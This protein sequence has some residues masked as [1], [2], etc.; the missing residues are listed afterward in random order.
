MAEKLELIQKH[1]KSCKNMI[2]MVK[3]FSKPIGFGGK[4]IKKHEGPSLQELVKNWKKS[5]EL[6]SSELKE[7]T[8]VKQQISYRSCCENRVPIIID[9]N[10]TFE[11][12]QPGYY[13]LQKDEV[14]SP[15]AGYPAIQ[16]LSDDVTIDLCGYSLTQGNAKL[17]VIGIQ[18][19]VL[20]DFTGFHNL[21]I[22]N[23]T[24]QKFT[25]AGIYQLTLAPFAGVSASTD[26]FLTDLR[27]LDCG[28]ANPGLEASGIYLSGFAFFEGGFQNVHIRD[29]TVARS[30]GNGGVIVAGVDGLWI[31]HT[32][33]LDTTDGGEIG[34]ANLISLQTFGNNINLDHVD[35]TGVTSDRTENFYTV[36]NWDC[37]FSFNITAKDC[38]FNN[39]QGAAPSAIFQLANINMQ[40]LNITAN[41]TTVLTEGLDQF[42]GSGN[43]IDRC[44]NVYC[45]NSQFNDVFDTASGGQVAGVFAQGAE[46]GEV[47]SDRKA[48]ENVKF[49]NCQFCNIQGVRSNILQGVNNSEAY[50]Q[51]FEGCQFNTSRGGPGAGIICGIHVSDVPF[52]ETSGDGY[53][54]INCQFNDHVRE[55]DSTNLSIA[56]GF[57]S[58]TKRNILFDGCEAINIR[59]F[60]ESV[61]SS[62]SGSV[63]GF[64]PGFA[65]TDPLPVG[66]NNRNVKFRKCVVSDLEGP[67]HVV[68]IYTGLFNR[69]IRV[70]ELGEG[71]VLNTTV[72][73]CIV[74]R[75]KSRA[76]DARLVAGIAEGWTLNANTLFN[77]RLR[78]E[79]RN[80]TV[81][82]NKV[83]AVRQETPAANSAGILAQSVTNPILRDNIVNDSDRGVLLTGSDDPSFE[84]FRV[85]ATQQNALDQMF[86]PFDLP[87]LLVT[88]NPG[89]NPIQAI[90]PFRFPELSSPIS[91][92]TFVT[93]TNPLTC[94]A[95]DPGMNGRIVVIEN[96]PDTCVSAEFLE[97]LAAAGAIGAVIIDRVGSTNYGGNFNIFAAVITGA[98]GDNLLQAL[99]N[100]PSAILTID[101]A[102]DSTGHGFDNVDTGDSVSTY[103]NQLSFVT[104]STLNLPDTWETGNA[105]VYQPI[106]DPIQGLVPGETYYAIV[107]R[108]GFSEC[109]LITHNDVTNCSIS[110]YQDDRYHT[111]SAWVDNTAFNNGTKHGD[112]YKIQWSCKKP[113]SEGNLAC[114]PQ[115][116][117]KSYNLSI[118][119]DNCK[120]KQD[121]YKCRKCKHH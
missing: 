40:L 9:D 119:K 58:I 6:V 106:G 107:Y 82:G 118:T 101:D 41:N 85:A 67:S 11:I 7:K 70:P 36:G 81:T 65:L 111:A 21:K 61:T 104:D 64:A 14:F 45:E 48:G 87:D 39:C 80:F 16:V 75:I 56:G 63:V 13:F 102:T 89:L 53:K 8:V 116:S 117:K 22:T 26:Y 51:V 60:K 18:I 84:G 91:G 57:V 38:T 120:P 19:G 79:M 52:Q 54:Y 25:R 32:Q 97:I 37:Y 77:V 47:F 108:P 17:S 78:P 90:W 73:D 105:M 112:N 68:G 93:Q 30:V 109:G 12:T 46:V 27:V 92:E 15:S 50:N 99:L 59:D 121:K 28:V 72:E 49:V 33:V 66:G 3:S 1:A 103:I 20:V 4:N 114:Y 10:A 5:Q 35:S 96:F 44:N 83:T 113:V 55:A 69:G 94:V 98:D 115:T 29:C 100:D 2:K 95:P 76:S 71:E 23:G 31:E 24:I 88:M 62:D 42:G 43:S 34:N 74:E 86:I 110:G